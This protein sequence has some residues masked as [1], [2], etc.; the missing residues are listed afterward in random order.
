MN[1][2]R[3]DSPSPRPAVTPSQ[4]IHADDVAAQRTQTP[5][6]P[7]GKLASTAHGVT[8]AT[9]PGD[10]VDAVRTRAFTQMAIDA[11]LTPATTQEFVARAAALDGGTLN[12]PAAADTQEAQARSPAQAKQG[13][14]RGE[15]TVAPTQAQAGLLKLLAAHDD[16]ENF[17]P[18]P[19]GASIGSLLPKPG[20]TFAGE[21]GRAGVTP[22]VAQAILQNVGEGKPPFKPDLGQDGIS[23][24][25]TKGNPYTGASPDKSVTVPVEITNPSGKPVVQLGEKELLEIYNREMTGATQVV[26][27]QLRER[28]GKVNGEP[29]SNTNLKEIN[30]NASRLAERSMWSRVAEAV[31]NS[32]SGVGKVELKG[33]VFS[34]HGDG[35]FTLTNRAENVRLP[36]GAT[37]ELLKTIKT[38]AAPAEPGVLEA[39]EKLATSEK[40]A[41]RV[42]GAYRVGG[43][44]LIVVGLAADAYRIYTATD[45]VKTSVEVAGG[46]GGATLAA[47]AFAAWYTPADVAGPWAWAGHAVGSLV[48][49]GVGYF[50]GSNV[51]REVYELTVEGKP[52]EIG[53]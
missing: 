7:T 50:V 6:Q 26:E 3:I 4:A 24:F 51:A 35:E 17:C 37:A 25:T 48:A 19:S 49:G 13:I 43:R 23:W 34:R 18:I 45:K 41:G 33:S 38:N 10:T 1:P 32:E 40:W 15:V 44:V 9:R 30:R 2:D 20:N 29:L 46:W 36:R 14:D 28:T 16:N 53:Q 8:V 11:G 12:A 22:E 5:A 31:H 21:P 42:E 27:Q 39:A 47:G 52:L